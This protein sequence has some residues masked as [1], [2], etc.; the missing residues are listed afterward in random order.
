MTELKIEIMIS[1]FMTGLYLLK[2]AQF[3]YLVFASLVN[4]LIKLAYEKGVNK[5]G[6]AEDLGRG[7]QS[8]LSWDRQFHAQR[9]VMGG[10]S[11]GSL[12]I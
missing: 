7:N 4:S 9:K 11:L 10:Y 1:Y 6:I 5:E 2:I 3:Y 8:N 12:R